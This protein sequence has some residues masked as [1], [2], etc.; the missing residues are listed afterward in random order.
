MG[1]AR[2]GGGVRLY[3][4]CPALNPGIDVTRLSFPAGVCDFSM[5]LRCDMY[6]EHKPGQYRSY[7]SCVHGQQ[8]S[9][10]KTKLS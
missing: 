8:E 4:E 7:H 3:N 2:K 1:W 9:T 10:I 6:N 5:L